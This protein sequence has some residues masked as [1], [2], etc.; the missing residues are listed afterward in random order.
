MDLMY[1]VGHENARESLG[2]ALAMGLTGMPAPW[3]NNRVGREQFLAT[4]RDRAMTYT[5][6]QF[7]GSPRF[8]EIAIE[9]A[10]VAVAKANGQTGALA[11][12]AL[13]AGV[14]NVVDQVAKLV[15][16]AA[17]HCAAEANAGHL[18]K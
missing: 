15:F 7:L 2:E 1:R 18:W 4:E 5:V 8:V 16:K 11:K 3:S 13:A 6:A 12:R 10:I 17:E 14:P 9:D